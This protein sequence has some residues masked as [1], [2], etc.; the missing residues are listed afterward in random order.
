MAAYVIYACAGSD[1][2]IVSKV[3]KSAEKSVDAICDIRVQLDTSEVLV[4]E[5]DF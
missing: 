1:G 3:R 2:D 5:I 4:R